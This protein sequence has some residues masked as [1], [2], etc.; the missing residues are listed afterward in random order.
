MKKLLTIALTFF[1]SGG[2][3]LMAQVPAPAK[4]DAPRQT[5]PGESVKIRTNS[6]SAKRATAGPDWFTP[7]ETIRAFNGGATSGYSFTTLFADTN[8][9]FVY[10][11]Q[12]GE[13]V[14]RNIINSA[15]IVFDPRSE[16]YDGNPFKTTLWSTYNVD[17]VRFAFFYRR[18]NTDPNMVDTIVVTVFDRTSITRGFNGIYAGA[19][20]YTTNQF[21]ASGTN[22]TTYKIF[23]TIDDTSSS[24]QERVI[25]INKTVLG[26][27]NGA[28]YFGA[29]V[30]YL[31]AYRGYS[32][33]E[34][35]DTVANFVASTTGP[36][37][38][39]TMRLLAYYDPSM[40]TESSTIP[41]INGT[42]IYNHGI[43][44]EPTQRYKLNSTVDYYF[45]AFYT[46]VH[47]FPAI[48]FHVSSPNISVNSL[49]N[50][51]INNIYP[52]P[53]VSGNVIVELKSDVNADANVEITDITGKVVKANISTLSIGNNELSLNVDGLS[54][55]V[56]FVS[57]KAE[58]INTVS[59]LIIE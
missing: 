54:K 50:A 49:T 43:V 33:T 46:T 21:T 24:A 6:N 17:S 34:P 53:A 56:Y 14:N 57:V 59:R 29:T 5:V 51:T 20:N 1:C 42:R 25:G 10:S 18:F 45:P 23:L 11:G 40:F 22:A 36:D 4:K 12:N 37:K 7:A 55:G 3:M 48:D 15:G 16:I 52:N 38:V 39:N 2:M 44:A 31:P 27:N 8:A 28:N 30:T 13:V 19:V 41:P 35:F 9:Y 26:S 32:K 47:M 58:G